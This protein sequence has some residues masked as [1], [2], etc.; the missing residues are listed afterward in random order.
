METNVIPT[1]E[2]CSCTFSDVPKD[3]RFD[4]DA[5]GIPETAISDLSKDF[6]FLCTRYS[7]LFTTKTRDTSYYGQA[8]ISG[9]LRNEK[10]QRRFTK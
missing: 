6:E 8:Y 9:L 4:A 2:N 1:P 7:K 5:W 10:T 3:I